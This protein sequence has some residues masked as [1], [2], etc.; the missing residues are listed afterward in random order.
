[1]SLNDKAVVTAAIGYVYVA[2]PGTPRPSPSALESIDPESFGSSSG[3][4]KASAVPTGGTF[5]L[6][7]GEGIVAPK[8]QVEE[9]TTFEATGVEP[10]TV[11]PDAKTVSTKTAKTAKAVEA[12]AVV[13]APSGTTLELPFDA[14]SAEVQ[15]ALE[16]ISEVGAG[17]VKVTGGG[18]LE[19][20]FVVSFIGELAGENIAVTVNSKLEPVS[21]TVDSA[22]VSAPNGWTSLGHTSREDLPEF[23]F[24]GGDTEVRG[25]WQNESLREV[26]TEPIADYLTIMLAQFDIPTF[27]LYY[28]KNASKT[29]GVFGVSGGTQA[30]VEKA[31]FIIIQDGETKIGFYAPK[32]SIRRDDSVELSVDE[33]AMLPVRATFLKYGSANKFEWI[34]EDLF[35]V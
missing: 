7:V 29:P 22:V 11:T 35:T 14:G 28:G 21:V 33:F 8:E 15:Q 6:T 17:N 26:V 24:D 19:D 2:D 12:P 1:M 34:N 9:V 16:N 32:A 4:L 3:S 20:G 27:E 18:F 13:A 25:T 31:L 30:P 23:G 5:S 10:P